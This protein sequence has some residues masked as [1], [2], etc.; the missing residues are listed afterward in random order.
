MTTSASVRLPAGMHVFERGWLSSNNILLIDEDSAALVDSGYLSHAEQ[1]LALVQTALQ[2]RAL[3]TLINTHLHSDHCGGNALLQS[4]YDCHTLIPVAELAAVQQWDQQLLSFAATGQRCERFR[5]DGCISPGDKL[6]LA[7]LEWQVLA[8]PGHDP[9]S[10]ML[11]C[12][13]EGILISAD[14]LWEHG[15]GV[16]FPELVAESGFAEQAAVLQLISELAP[17]LVISG[18]GAPF[19]EVSAALDRARGRLAYLS[20]DTSR[21]SRHALKVLIAFLLLDRQKFS[22]QEIEQQLRVSRL[23]TAA[24]AQLA[25]PVDLLIRQLAGELVSAGVARLEGEFLANAR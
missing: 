11:Y 4:V 3:T 22:L 15:F 6:R 18:H 9:H 23:M 12:V 13:S 16:I 1:T 2:G 25:I 14:A 17:R 10:M 21:N 24:A 8:A 19:T 20:A 5:Q 7:N